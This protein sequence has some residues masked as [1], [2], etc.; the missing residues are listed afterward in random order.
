MT[1]ATVPSIETSAPEGEESIVSHPT[2]GNGSM[3]GAAVGVGVA[4]V[5]GIVVGTAV[6][7]GVATVV[8]TVVGTAVGVGVGTVVAIVVGTIVGATVTF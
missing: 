1:P 3:V 5:V 2:R 7:V 8:G 4:T 6:G